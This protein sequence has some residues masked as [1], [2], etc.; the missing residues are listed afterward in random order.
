MS[1][2]LEYLLTGAGIGAGFALVGSGLVVISLPPT[3]PTPPL[4]RGRPGGAPRS[5]AAVLGAQQGLEGAH[6]Q[7]HTP[8]APGPDGD[9]N[10]RRSA[11]WC[12][13]STSRSR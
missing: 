11:S 7:P 9:R 13:A 4:P 12:C 5:R 10:A 6:R 2:L 1:Q 3:L 8:G